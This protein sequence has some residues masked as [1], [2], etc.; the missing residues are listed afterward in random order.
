MHAGLLLDSSV[1]YP[2]HEQLVHYAIFI[3]KSGIFHLHFPC[4]DGVDELMFRCHSMRFPFC[5]LSSDPGLPLGLRP[6]SVGATHHMG[7]RC[8]T[9]TEEAQS[10]TARLRIR[11]VPERKSSAVARVAREGFTPGRWDVAKAS[12]FLLF[13]KVD[14][15]VSPQ[16]TRAANSQI[17]RASCRE[18]V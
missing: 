10:E 14:P 5:E 1:R 11:T 2:G 15:T 17:G 4:Y 18:R 6:G 13:W 9:Q 3:G 8:G 12:K 16:V 7:S